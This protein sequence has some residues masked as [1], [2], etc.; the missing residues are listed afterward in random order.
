MKPAPEQGFTVLL[1]P[2]L[3]APGAEWQAH[4]QA[5]KAAWLRGDRVGV[6]RSP[7]CVDQDQPEAGVEYFETEFHAWLAVLAG[8][9]SKHGKAN[10]LADVLASLRGNVLGVVAVPFDSE[11][12]P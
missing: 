9:R 8:Q 12:A 3:E 5:I 1:E 4:R 2:D 10:R 11:D 6:V 7:D